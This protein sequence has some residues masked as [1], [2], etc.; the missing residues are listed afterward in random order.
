MPL[1]YRTQVHRLN[2]IPKPSAQKTK[3]Q[4]LLGLFFGGLL[5]VIIFT[6]I[7][8]SYGIMAGLCAGLIFGTSEVIY[9]L[10]RHKKV[11]TLTWVGNGLL[12]LLGLISLVAQ[13]GIWFKLQP[14]LFEAGFFIFLLGSWFLKKPFLRFIIEK[15][16]PETPD[17]LKETL[18]G[19]TL[20]LS[21]FMLAHAILA[22]WAAFEW[23]TRHWALLK[24]VGLTVSL[25]L[26]IGAEILWLRFKIKKIS[27]K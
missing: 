5:P 21:L 10:I 1:R 27:S 12:I 23:S 9:E 15:Q 17:F 14:A 19:M 6:V 4:Q 24:G 13:N 7:E 3:K 16:N 18:S 25:I 8:E 11:S 22:T 2:S 20:R 26:Y